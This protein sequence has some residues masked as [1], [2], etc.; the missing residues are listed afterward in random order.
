MGKRERQLARFLGQRD[1]KKKEPLEIDG[2]APAYFKALKLPWCFD[3][4]YEKLFLIVVT[5][6]GLWKAWE[7]LRWI[8]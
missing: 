4:V 1:P 7:L 2:L 5:Y 8:F 3:K 6:L